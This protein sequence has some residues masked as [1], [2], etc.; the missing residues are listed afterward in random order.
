[1]D[2]T[3]A[4]LYAAVT[5]FQTL[6]HA[7]G[8]PS[9][10]QLYASTLHPHITPFWQGL[11]FFVSSV[12]PLTTCFAFVLTGQQGLYFLSGLSVLFINLDTS[13]HVGVRMTS[14]HAQS[15]EE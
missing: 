11:P 7:I 1:M 4:A 14:G 9:L 10:Q 8:D 2:H 3:K 15:P 12:S 13:A 6:G 5:V